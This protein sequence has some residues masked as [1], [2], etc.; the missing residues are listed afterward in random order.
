MDDAV[1]FWKRRG[2]LADLEAVGKTV[3]V[4]P[5]TSKEMA[6]AT[7]AFDAGVKTPR[8]AILFAVCR[9]KASEGMDFADARCRCVLVTGIP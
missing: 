9:G 7:R 1:N 6:A 4:E 2:Q 3:V 8:G 5:R